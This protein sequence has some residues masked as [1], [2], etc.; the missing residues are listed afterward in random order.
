LRK[1]C[2]ASLLVE[3]SSRPEYTRRLTF[4]YPPDFSYSD[5]PLSRGIPR[6][7]VFQGAPEYLQFV[8]SYSW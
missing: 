3:Q 4:K 1:I 7:L 6:V 2:P 5:I 8:H